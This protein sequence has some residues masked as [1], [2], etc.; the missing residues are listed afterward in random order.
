LDFVTKDYAFPVFTQLNS[1]YYAARKDGMVFDEVNDFYENP[2]DYKSDF[3]HFTSQADIFI[4][5]IYWD[6]DAPA[7]FS[8]EDMKQEDFKIKVIAD[9]TCDIAPVSSIPS[10]L[11]ASTIP[12]PVFGFDPLNGKETDAFKGDCIDMMTIDNLPNELPRDA[13]TAFG[14]MFLEHVLPELETSNSDVI[15]RATLCENGQLGSHFQYL[16]NY[17]S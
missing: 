11:R 10:T 13:S 4:N 7:F 6:N 14:T 12:D 5:G 8:L 15:E 17:V 9:V 1:F 3:H 2:K 16:K